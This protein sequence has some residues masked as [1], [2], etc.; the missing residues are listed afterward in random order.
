MY[1]CINVTGGLGGDA[2]LVLGES[3]TALFDTGMAYCASTLVDNIK[4]ALA[5]QGRSEQ[6]LHYVFLSHSHYDHLGAL[7]FLRM[8]WP[9]LVACGA[10]HA[11]K[12]L[13]RPNALN[14][15]RELSQGAATLYGD[16][17]LE[18]YSDDLMKI[19]RC[20][21][22]E[23]II[24]LGNCPVQALV[25]QGHT[26][27]SL[28]FLVDGQ[29]MFASESTG[30][31]SKCGRVNTTFVTSYRL[32]MSSIDRCQSLK[33][34]AIVS[35]HYGLLSE[36]ETARYWDLCRSSTEDMK[37]FILSRLQ[38]DLS[39]EAV[40]DACYHVYYDDICRAEQPYRAWRLNTLA[41]IQTIKNEFRDELVELAPYDASTF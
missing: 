9:A 26:R 35:P 24:E 18:K 1:Q 33:P 19:D 17:N 22:D 38:E 23:E 31:T 34:K 11:Q 37:E 7:P 6:D 15:I 14:A 36:E 13:L 2:H 29:L 8:A 25:T 10:S 28:T 41:A 5:D 3:S 40:L 20:L 30:Y 39:D 21:C 4:K 27:C 32:A 12:V 16:G